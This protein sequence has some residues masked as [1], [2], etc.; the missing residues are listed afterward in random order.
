VEGEVVTALNILVTND[1]GIASPGL[2]HLAR[3]ALEAGHRV[4]VA[5]PAQESS[6]SSAA[7]SAVETDGRV[8]T[9]SRDIGLDSAQA[10]AVWG[11]PA[12]IT[13]LALG[14]AFGAR[15]DVILSGVNRGAN[16]GRAVLHSGTVGAALTAA[17]AGLRGIAVSLDVPSPGVA[18]VA[19]VTGDAAP[20]VIDEGHNWSTPARIAVD[21]LPAL[22][23]APPGVAFNVNAPDVHHADLLG[24]R[25]AKLAGLG[26]VQMV[27]AERGAGFVRTSVVEEQ[28]RPDP[29]TDLA[30]LSEGFACVTVI[31]PL[32]EVGGITLDGFSR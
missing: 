18:A 8:E 12:L 5:A 2:R 28:R 21:L 29:G 4:T 20:Q 16:T 1:D 14:E 30:L 7:M 19:V 27:V 11:T 15:P 22:M 17:S 13:R 25:Q 32:S 24:V 26:H 6:G 3:A 23:A 31:R 10:L 9:E